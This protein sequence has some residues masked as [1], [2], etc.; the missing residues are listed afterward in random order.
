[1]T[2]NKQIIKTSK[3]PVQH[4]RTVTLTLEEWE[5]WRRAAGLHIDPKT[6]EVRWDYRQVVNPYGVWPDIPEECDCI[7]RAYFARSP[8]MNVWIEFGDLPDSTRKTLWAKHQDRLAFPA[9]L[10]PV[11][12]VQRHLEQVE[13]TGDLSED[14]LLQAIIAGF[15]AYLDQKKNKAD[16][17]EED[18][19]N[20]DKGALS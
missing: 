12:F 13:S 8:G 17:H 5:A 3:T 15:Q 6:A 18:I 14:E 20:R 2:S 9:G 1:M 19:H 7:R 16:L 11:F 4:G 10:E